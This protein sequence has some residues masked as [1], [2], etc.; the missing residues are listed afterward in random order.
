MRCDKMTPPTR[1]GPRQGPLSGKT[2]GRGIIMKKSSVFCVL[3]LIALT[4]VC[5]HG[6]DTG[7]CRRPPALHHRGRHGRIPRQ[8]GLRPGPGGGC[9]RGP[10]GSRSAQKKQRGDEPAHRHDP[11]TGHRGQGPADHPVQRLAR[12]TST[13]RIS[14]SPRRSPATRSQTRSASRSGTSRAGGVSG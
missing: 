10:H 13:T 9:H 1:R 8:A 3:V 11:Q 6:P 14:R 12:A 7:S 2:L 5:G 4:S